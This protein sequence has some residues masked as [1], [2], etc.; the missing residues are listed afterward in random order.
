MSSFGWPAV[1]ANVPIP[2]TNA[3]PDLFPAFPA[4][5]PY[6]I[7]HPDHQVQMTWPGPTLP[8][9]H[10][11]VPGRRGP[12]L[13]CST[14][15]YSA[16]LPPGPGQRQSVPLHVVLTRAASFLCYTTRRSI[17]HHTPVH[18]RM[19]PE[20]PRTY[21]GQPAHFLDYTM[22]PLVLGQVK[23]RGHNLPMLQQSGAYHANRSPYQTRPS[24]C[25]HQARL[26]V[27]AAVVPRL[28]SS[29]AAEY[30]LWYPIESHY[31][32]PV[33]MPG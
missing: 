26:L 33:L 21:A 28:A 8:A 30:S 1:L 4:R 19:I 7:T 29:S 18:G 15:Q 17:P 5:L 31:C 16:H 13:Y 10:P 11:G 24:R 3:L 23:A 32:Y 20:R 6:Y 25:L 2:G 9:P 27:H 22:P 12:A 14:L